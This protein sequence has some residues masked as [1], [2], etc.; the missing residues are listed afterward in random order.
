LY[1][2]AAGNLADQGKKDEAV[3]LLDKMEKGISI[4]N[5]PYA[6]VSRY[7]S[8]NQTGL[9]YLEAAYKAGKKDLAEKIKTALQTDFKQQE[10]YYNY[11]KAERSEFFEAMATEE[12]I[13]NRMMQVMGTIVAKYEGK[14][15]TPDQTGEGN[16]SITNPGKVSVPADT[17][18][19]PQ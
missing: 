6:M 1:G 10:D 7:N 5:L 14:A 2:E 8:H 18:K 17:G 9:L 13:N 3:A 12:L 16:K 11:I 15:T 19:K 4:E